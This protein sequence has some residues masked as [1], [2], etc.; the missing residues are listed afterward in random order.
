[1][2]LETAKVF[3]HREWPGDWRV[4]W[5]DDDGGVE[6]AIF[7]GPNARE[8]GAPLRRSAIRQF[9]GSQPRAVFRSLAPRPAVLAVGPGSGRVPRAVAGALAAAVHS[10]GASAR[11]PAIPVLIV[12]PPHAWAAT[13][14]SVSRRKVVVSHRA[15]GKLPLGQIFACSQ[16]MG[17]C[18]KAG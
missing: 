6:V 3:E 9:P 10:G 16:R 13:V 17:E 12:A 8:R 4:E 1:M 14:V 7:S 11:V 15:G 18:T 5:V 2:D